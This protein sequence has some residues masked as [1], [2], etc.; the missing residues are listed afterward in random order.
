MLINYFIYCSSHLLCSIKQYFLSLYTL[1]SISWWISYEGLFYIYFPKPFIHTCCTNFEIFQPC[2]D[3][4]RF[5]R[6][7]FYIPFCY[8]FSVMLLK[9]E[10]YLYTECCYQY[11][12]FLELLFLVH[13]KLQN[14]YVHFPD[15]PRCFSFS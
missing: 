3:I 5:F 2:C 12:S 4:I 6:K 14:F 9:H 11:I 1:I 8:Y 13:Y 7:G 15:C 10:Y